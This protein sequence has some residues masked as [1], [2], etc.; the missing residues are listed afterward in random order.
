M[1]ILNRLF[2]NKKE[3]I[4]LTPAEVQSICSFI[5]FSNINTKL[6]ADLVQQ[7]AAAIEALHNL[8]TL[9]TTTFKA[10]WETLEGKNEDSPEV[11][12]ARFKGLQ[13]QADAAIREF[14]YRQRRCED[15]CNELIRFQKVFGKQDK[16]DEGGSK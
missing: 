5:D 16:E 2:R 9:Y 1:D 15:I 14:E 13:D 12:E 6:L 3:G 7:Q 8:T 10:M 4:M 11:L